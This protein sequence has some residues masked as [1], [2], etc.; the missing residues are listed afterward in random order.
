[1]KSAILIIDVQKA[2]FDSEPQ[3]YEADDVVDKINTL[4]TAARAKGIDVVFIHHE[5]PNTP[6]EYGS[7]GW[8]LY[9]R[10]VHVES[11]TV[12]RK[13]TPDS[14]FETNLA[15]FLQENGIQNLMV[16]GYATE[17]CV[18][19]TVRRAAAL[20]YSVQ[21]ISDA[22]TTHDKDHAKASEIRLHHN[23]TLPNVSSFK[24]DITLIETSQVRY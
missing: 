1:M 11:D 4:T 15:K 22:H 13:T 2:L 16:C 12:I 5:A 18:D 10:L 8:D 9:D 24:G 6:M 19:T 21:L 3:P 20:G 17:F 23:S 14:F 7:R